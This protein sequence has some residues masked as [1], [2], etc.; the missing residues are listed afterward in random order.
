MPL[1]CPYCRRRFSST[2]TINFSS[3]KGSKRAQQGPKGPTKRPKGPTAIEERG[4]LSERP[5][6]QVRLGDECVA[7]P[8]RHGQQRPGVECF[9]VEDEE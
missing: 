6:W 7:S 3:Q 9:R 5:A 8:H 1:R 4:G 2:N